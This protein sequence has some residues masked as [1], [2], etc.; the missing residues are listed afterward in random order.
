MK[1]GGNYGWKNIAWGGTEYSGRK[2]GNLAL[3]NIYD[4][5]L[6]V[7]VP[8]IGIG[9]FQFYNGSA[10]KSWNGDILVTATKTKMLIRLAI[11][12]NQIISEEII[13]K[14]KIGRIRD[15]EVDSQG[16]IYLISDES[17]SGLWKMTK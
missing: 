8:S 9:N 5:P 10:F 16:N 2:I 4:E 11:K 1:F 3:S 12:E 15:L 17:R 14:D 13:L 7:W 6:K